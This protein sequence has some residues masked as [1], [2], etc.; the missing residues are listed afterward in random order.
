MRSDIENL[1]TD[2]ES[3][4][5]VQINK[6]RI[7]EADNDKTE[8]ITQNINECYVCQSCDPFKILTGSHSHVLHSKLFPSHSEITP[9]AKFDKMSLLVRDVSKHRILGSFVLEKLSEYNKSKK[10]NPSLKVK[11]TKGL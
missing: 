2:S 7:I 3:E 4:T 8:D 9:L 6:H 5:D 11:I 1:F 10:G